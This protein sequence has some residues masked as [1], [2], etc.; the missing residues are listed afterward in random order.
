[1]LLPRLLIVAASGAALVPCEPP[2]PPSPVVCK[3][4]K[5]CS[6]V[7][8]LPN[9]SLALLAPLLLLKLLHRGPLCEPFEQTRLQ[10]FGWWA[11]CRATLPPFGVPASLSRVGVDFAAFGGLSRKGDRASRENSLPPLTLGRSSEVA[12]LFC[13]YYLDCGNI[14]IP[15]DS[16]PNASSW[17]RECSSVTLVCFFL[18]SAS[19]SRFF[20]RFFF[21]FCFSCGASCGSIYPTRAPGTFEA[22][23]FCIYIC[24]CVCAFVWVFV[25]TCNHNKGK[26]SAGYQHPRDS[27]TARHL[28]TVKGFWY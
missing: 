7:C 3:G 13:T 18:G 6:E 8:F 28:F 17:L 24:M 27:T 10:P 2:P 19:V 11:P 1:M 15:F 12:S 22:W 9:P 25:H 4:E 5:H 16:C 20:A 23:V 14:S 21:V 26:H